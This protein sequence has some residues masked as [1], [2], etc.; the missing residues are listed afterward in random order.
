MMLHVHGGEFGIGMCMPSAGRLFHL[1]SCLGQALVV[2]SIRCH[3]RRRHGAVNWSRPMRGIHYSWQMRVRHCGACPRPGII[4]VYVVSSALSIGAPWP[5]LR[6]AF[7]PVFG[8]PCVGP[9]KA[10]GVHT[11]D[12]SQRSASVYSSGLSRHIGG[13]THVGLHTCGIVLVASAL[14]RP[15][16]RRARDHGRRIGACGRY[17]Q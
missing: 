13:L 15:R 14:A 10:S 11:S 3:R 4:Y 8:A 16:R 2:Q 6:C 7:V 17:A 12:Y 5:A 1:T 9:P